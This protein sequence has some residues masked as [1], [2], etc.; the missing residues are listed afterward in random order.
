MTPKEAAKELDLSIARIH[1]LCNA[2]RLGY[3]QPKHGRS[4]V[5]T[6]HEIA[7]FRTIG[8]LPAGAPKKSDNNS[9][10]E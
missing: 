9:A 2:G 1:Q 5:I 8:P 4:W 7:R 6:P 3:S 10:A